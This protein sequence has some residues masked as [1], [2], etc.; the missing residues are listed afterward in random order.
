MTVQ[1]L[2]TSIAGKMPNT[3]VDQDYLD[4]VNELEQA[5][6]SDTVKEFTG[7]DIALVSDQAAYDF[8]TGY[9]I[10]DIEAAFL[11]D[12]ELAKLDLRQYQKKGYYSETG[13]LTLYPIPSQTDAEGEESLHVVCRTKPAVKL[14]ANITTDALL[15]PDAFIDLYRYYIYSQIAY[16]REQFTTGDNWATKFNAKMSDFKIWYENNRPKKRVTYKKRWN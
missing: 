7:F 10:L 12:I 8:P 15:L 3:L 2:I 5:V 9:T 6:Y 14:I 16:L 4:F 13:K 11:N 1:A